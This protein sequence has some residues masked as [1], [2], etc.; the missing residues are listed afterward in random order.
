MIVKRNKNI[1]VAE[2]TWMTVGY[3]IIMVV[4]TNLVFIGLQR[5][6]VYAMGIFYCT[7]YMEIRE[8]LKEWSK[9]LFENRSKRIIGEN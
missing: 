9:K 4:V 3:I 5:Y 2:F 1:Q 7:L 8:V 6:M